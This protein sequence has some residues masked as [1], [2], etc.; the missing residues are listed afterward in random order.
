MA[1][2]EVEVKCDSEVN[3]LFAKTKVIQKLKK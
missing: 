2:Y 1:N 3:E